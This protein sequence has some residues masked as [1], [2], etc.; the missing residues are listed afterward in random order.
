VLFI[1]MGL[2]DMMKQSNQSTNE[3]AG[4]TSRIGGDDKAAKSNGASKAQA[5]HAEVHGDGANMLSNSVWSSDGLLSSSRLF[6]RS[7]S[8][9]PIHVDALRGSQR[10]SSTGSNAFGL[11]RFHLRETLEENNQEDDPDEIDRQDL[12]MPI[13]KHIQR[14]WSAPPVQDSVSDCAFFAA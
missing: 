4:G 11:S 5:K 12:V 1:S 8:T 9:P 2:T 3:D 6:Q 13:G 10:Q 14:A 7:S